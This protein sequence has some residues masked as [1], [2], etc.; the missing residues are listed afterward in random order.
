MPKPKYLQ[1]LR[2]QAFKRQ[3]GRCFYCRM[4]IW[5]TDP[6]RFAHRYGI[7]LAASRQFRCTAEHLHARSDGGSDTEVN[8]V[9]ACLFCNGHRHRTRVPLSPELFLARVRRRV[10]AGRWNAM[11]AT[12]AK[13]KTRPS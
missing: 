6:M 1:K 3:S 11:L 12:R 7:S 13:H 8:V 2:M 4:P 5:H 9:A 10:A